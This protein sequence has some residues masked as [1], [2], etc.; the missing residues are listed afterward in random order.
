MRRLFSR[1]VMYL[2]KFTTDGTLTQDERNEIVGAAEFALNLWEMCTGEEV[3]KACTT[4][5]KGKIPLEKLST[6]D[7]AFE[8]EKEKGA[9]DDGKD[10]VSEKRKDTALDAV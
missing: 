3:F 10:E 8:A 5:R 1:A 2:G 7:E 4:I 9:E 6:Y